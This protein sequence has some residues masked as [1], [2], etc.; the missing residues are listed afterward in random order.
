MQAPHC[1]CLILRLAL[2]YASTSAQ[3]KRIFIEKN[4]PLYMK[5]LKELQWI[6]IPTSIIL[7]R[8]S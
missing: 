7:P 8:V 2:Q 1:I 3:S 4:H 5:F 6:P